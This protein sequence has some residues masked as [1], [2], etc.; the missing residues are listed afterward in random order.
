M[1]TG[2]T[3]N[4]WRQ[5]PKVELHRHLEGSFHLETLFTIAQ[6]NKLDVPRDFPGFKKAF[7]FPKDSVPDFHLFLSKFKQNWY[8]SL[9]DIYTLA[10]ESVKA[11]KND[12]L[13]Y[14]EL[15]FNPESFSIFNNFDR[16][17]VTSLV[18]EA[19][20]R[21]AA[22]AGLRIRYLITFNRG[23]CGEDYFISLYKKIAGLG[24]KEIVGIDL[25]GDEVNYPI[26]LFPK[27][28]SIVKNDGLYKATIHAGEVTPASEIWEAIKLHAARIGHGTASVNDAELQ[29]C[30]KENSIALEQCITSNYQ[31]GS[32]PDETTHPINTL[33]RLG[34]PVT[35]NSDD[36]TIQDTD[37]SDDYAKAEK[38]FAFT[39][40]DF[41]SLNLTA[42]QSTFVPDS[43]KEA[44]QNDYLQAVGDFKD[45]APPHQTSFT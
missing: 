33:Y 5:F 9:D 7:Q 41:V 15:R 29:K 32:W 26:K 17:E 6:K 42:I 25:A 23:Q 37:L 12:G 43:E 18:I 19:G 11:I 31:T 27:F 40:N 34:V 20:N 21:A 38:H 28:F 45:T 4:T 8:R 36:P 2:E 22:E 30:L 44:L 39:L 14:V 13:F 35:L 24:K 3:N 16:S 1:Q 10:Y